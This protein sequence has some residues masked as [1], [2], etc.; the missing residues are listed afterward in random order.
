MLSF[1]N[2]SLGEIVMSFLVLPWQLEERCIGLILGYRSCSL[3]EFSK[4]SI[5]PLLARSGP[6]VSLC[7]AGFSDGLLPI[8]LMAVLAAL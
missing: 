6:T 5:H 8:G 4:A 7:N 1:S 2:C 3:G